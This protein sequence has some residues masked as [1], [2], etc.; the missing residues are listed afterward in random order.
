MS[1][2]LDA[3]A[4]IVGGNAL[5]TDPADVAPYASDW[6]GKLHGRPLAV[7]RP[8]ST[9]QVA[10]V[11]R[12]CGQ[13]GIA[14]VPQGGNSGLAGG[15]TPDASGT[16]LILS[17]DRMAAIRAVD[18][19][20]NVIVAEAGCILA[21][22]QAAAVEADRL[23][24]LS[25]A[26]EGSA[27]IGGAIA[28]N[29]GGLNVLR[30]GNARALVLGLEIVLPDGQVL[31]LL[32]RLRKD[33]AGYDL[34]QLFIGSEGTLGIVTAASLRLF[35]RIVQRQTAVL[36]LPSL[37]AVL[38]LH[39]RLDADLG[40]FLSSF[41]LISP[42]A[43]R[44]AV[45]HLPKASWPFDEGWAVLIEAG[46]GNARID[47]GDLMETALGAAIEAGLVED[48]VIA[49]SEAQRQGLWLVR[50]SITEGERA[51]GPSVK[52]DVSVPLS[53]LPAVI[54]ACEEAVGDRFPGARVNAFGHVGDGNIHFNVI[55]TPEQWAQPGFEAA[56][57]HLVH[58]RIVAEGGSITAEHGVGRLRV[59]ELT[60][61]KS[62]TA[63][64]LMAQI[65]RLLDPAG[66]MNPGAVLRPVR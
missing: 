24:P 3:L 44:L 12:L 58:D 6:R 17:L 43:H 53:R 40:E 20:D 46:S 35:P 15:A 26:A 51:I 37:E 5:L 13:R 50:E 23:L 47:L 34:K 25:F 64:A 2:G 16:Q 11:V 8:A 63:I 59:G 31:D 42:H 55:P 7:A 36:R 4:A 38:G 60:H 22:A 52:H 56:L 19:V 33:N 28:T 45:A 1:Y 27:R 54:I 32:G 65:K 10:A 41:E 61:Y 21:H 62:P 30:Y 9:G 29:A 66:G 48:A 39:Q 18:P 57:N 49:Q 14:I